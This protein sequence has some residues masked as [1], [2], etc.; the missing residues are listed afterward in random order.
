VSAA[1]APHADPVAHARA[2]TF[3]NERFRAVASGVLE[4]MGTTFLLLIA[5]RYFH[6]GGTEKAL[7][8][9]GQ[10][11][12]LLLSPVA[13]SVVRRLG[14]IPS[15]A[16]GRLHAAAALCLLL[17]ALF[18]S[19]LLFTIAYPLGMMLA[20][21]TIPLFTQ[22][23]QDN[24]P[25]H[26]RGGLF[27]ATAVIRIAVAALFS[28]AAGRFLGADI[29]RVPIL[30]GIFAAA[31][32]CSAWFLGRCPSRPLHGRGESAHPLH[33]LRYVG[34]D[35]VFRWTLISWMLMGFGNLVTLPLRVEYLANP[36]Y[37]I[38]LDPAQ[39]A[40]YTGVIPNLARLVMSRVW[41]YLFDRVNFFL[42]RIV[43]NVGFI[44]GILA[45]FTGGSTAGLVIGGIFFG[46]AWA[47]GD[48]AWSLWVTK[49]APAEKVAEYM[50]VHTFFT[51]IRGIAA[52]FVAFAA[53]E[54]FTVG[55]IGVAGTLLIVAASLLLLPEVRTFRPRRQGQPL[56]PGDGVKPSD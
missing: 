13:V 51:G 5:N 48:V 32:A 11:F 54:R 52:P 14:W 45:F 18:P 34:S 39:I 22:M 43:L 30:L 19:A 17:P 44:L 4:S 35:R 15:V 3:R 53:V 9:A 20:A 25:A 38:T 36:R 16:A 28:W 12:G 1:A 40:L 55:Q 24:Y 27:T 42:L 10:S 7:L 50:S 37:G 21:S 33:A 46:V 23:Y 29:G 47:G 56:V 31:M 26:E 49:I 2:V 41:G 6:A 8:V